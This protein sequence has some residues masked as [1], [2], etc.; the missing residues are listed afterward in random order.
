VKL[1]QEVSQKMKVEHALLIGHHLRGRAKGHQKF[2]GRLYKPQRNEVCCTHH[3][4]DLRKRY[5]FL[6]TKEKTENAMPTWPSIKR[7]ARKQQEH[8][9][10]YTQSAQEKR[11]ILLGNP[12][13]PGQLHLKVPNV[14]SCARKACIAIH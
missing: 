5:E 12:F 9:K 13:Y 1:A 8:C 14:R 11:L 4:R 7:Q 6:H 2:R 3:Q 10:A